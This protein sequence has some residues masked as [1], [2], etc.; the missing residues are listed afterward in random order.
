MT[1]TLPALLS[2]SACSCRRVFGSP[3]L[4]PADGDDGLCTTC[5]EFE[6]HRERTWLAEGCGMRKSQLTREVSR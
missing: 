5:R 2:V 6:G 4:E 1:A 3:C